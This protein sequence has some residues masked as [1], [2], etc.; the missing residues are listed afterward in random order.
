MPY[1]KNWL[2]KRTEYY[3]EQVIDT[4]ESALFSGMLVRLMA[5]WKWNVLKVQRS[6]RRLVALRKVQIS[7]WKTS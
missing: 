6:M 5:S 7:I 1:I 4:I 3:R 2:S